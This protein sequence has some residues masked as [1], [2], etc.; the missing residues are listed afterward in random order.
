[1][2][3]SPDEVDIT[4]VGAA[5]EIHKIGE[6]YQKAGFYT[7]I[8]HKSAKTLFSTTDPRFHAA[9]RRLLAG[10][11]S[12]A[13]MVNFEPIVADRVNLC[14]KRMGEEMQSRGVADVYK[15]WTFL[16]TDTVGELS[17]GESFRMLEYGKVDPFL[18][19]LVA[20]TVL[21]D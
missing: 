20:R 21:I 10:P 5:K 13:S 2:R 11:M 18:Q 9:R 6:R 19:S 12:E 8:G 14:M 1:M 3:V 7:H 15:W 17:F 4:D 16:A